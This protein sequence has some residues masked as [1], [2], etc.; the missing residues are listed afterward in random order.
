[1]NSR[2]I[3]KSGE[4]EMVEFKASL[5]EWRDAVETLSAFS[6]RNGGKLF[7][8]ITDKCEVIG[9]D[10]GKDTIE[11]LANRIRQNTDPVIHPSICVEGIDGKQVIVVDVGESVQKP[12]LAIGRGF[13]RVGKSNQ[14]LG[15]ES[16]TNPP[17]FEEGK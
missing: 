7:I 6:N 3:I 15:Y 2:E 13:M 11:K 1:M 16:R 8:G 17:S 14:K 4:S 5:T 9:V 12:V 10:V